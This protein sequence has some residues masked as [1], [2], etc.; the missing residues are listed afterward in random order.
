[1]KKIILCLLI[2][3]ILISC[4][5]E[6]TNPFI[7]VTNDFS[8][9]VDTNQIISYSISANAG[10][11]NLSKIEVQYQSNTQL[12]KTLLDSTIQGRTFNYLFQY[13]VV[14]TTTQTI[15]LDFTVTDKNG[16]QAT[17]SKVINII[18]NSVLLVETAGN[19]MYTN[20]AYN[21]NAYNLLTCKSLNSKVTAD[22]LMHIESY[23]DSTNIDTVTHKWVSPAKL[24][25]VTDNGFDYANA[26]ITSASNAFE[27]G[28][29]LSL[30][31]NINVGDIIITKITS[32]KI[33]NYV[34]I[35]VTE[36][37]DNPGSATDNY[38][39]NIKK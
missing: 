32:G 12:L 31:S 16:N 5:K 9:T 35:K 38:T 11:A 22:S 39:F 20:A 36:I 33:I 15:Y 24:L 10:T 29:K 3:G 7:L 25:F 28:V 30:V 21:P 37:Y 27:S 23:L 34:V 6:N 1:M 17:T 4:K 14:V 19:V 18:Q 2:I 26:T 13:P 8:I